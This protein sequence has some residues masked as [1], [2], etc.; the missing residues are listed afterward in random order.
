MSSSGLLKGLTVFAVLAFSTE[1]GP[2][3]LDTDASNFGLG[4]VLSQI[5]N[6]GSVS[7]HTVAACFDPRI[8][9]TARLSERCWLLSPCVL[10]FVLICVA[11]SLLFVPTIS[12]SC[13]SIVLKTLRG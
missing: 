7:L 2:Y 13:G 12:P 1:T 9:S 6:D 3:I 5:Q 10:S 4:G 8:G 11:L